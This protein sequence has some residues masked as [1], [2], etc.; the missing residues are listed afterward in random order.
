MKPVNFED[1]YQPCVFLC[2]DVAAEADLRDFTK[3][4][5]VKSV[6]SQ[7]HGELGSFIRTGIRH[8]GGVVPQVVKK[9][10]AIADVLRR[11]E[12]S[13]VAPVKSSMKRDGHDSLV[14]ATNTSES[15]GKLHREKLLVA[16]LAVNR[17][18][19]Q[20]VHR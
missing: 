2:T 11:T 4:T 15:R 12:R 13:A 1:R 5:A 19:T 20:A 9:S 6:E 18:L 3:Q 7:E 10:A 17:S 14:V 16:P 8:T